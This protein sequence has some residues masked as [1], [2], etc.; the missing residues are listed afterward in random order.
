MENNNV[1]KVVLDQ[2]GEAFGLVTVPANVREIE[3]FNN[4]SIDGT[5]ANTYTLKVSASKTNFAALK[6][7]GGYEL[8]SHYAH[9]G[10]DYYRF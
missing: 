3:V 10:C 2:F 4:A 8:F 9:R 7:K 5:P 1:E 6:R